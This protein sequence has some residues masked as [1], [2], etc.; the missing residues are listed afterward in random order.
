MR[1][2]EFRTLHNLAFRYLIRY[3]LYL[4][5]LI[6]AGYSHIESQILK[7]EVVTRCCLALLWY[8]R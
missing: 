8:W 1:A 6:S 4:P 2:M 3:V 5:S 7:P